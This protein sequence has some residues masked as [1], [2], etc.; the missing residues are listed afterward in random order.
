MWNLFRSQ[1]QKKNNKRNLI[2]LQ[3]QY[4]KIPD[5]IEA[6]MGYKQLNIRKPG[7]IVSVYDQSIWIPGQANVSSCD[8]SYRDK[9]ESPDKT[10]GCGFHAYKKIESLV[11]NDF[12]ISCYLWG[13]VFIYQEGYRSQFAYPAAIYLYG[14]R[15]PNDLV[16]A[17]AERYGISIKRYRLIEDII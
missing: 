15:I 7:F 12:V 6:P 9:H 5:R 1:F 3:N 16:K 10:C 2:K 4:I 14:D 11:P 13:R 8:Y 17:T